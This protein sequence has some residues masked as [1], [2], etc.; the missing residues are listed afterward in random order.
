VPESFRWFVTVFM[1]LGGALLARV[2]AARLFQSARGTLAPAETLLDCTAFFS[3]GLTLIFVQFVDQYF[4]IYLPLA[5]IVVGKS[6]QDLLLRWRA[7][8]SVCCVF[9]LVGATVWTREDLARDEA[10]WT[11]SEQLR[12]E[13]IPAERIFSDWKWLFYWQFEDYVHA[14]HAT[15]ETSYADLFEDGWLK[16]KKEAA[17]F[18]IVRELQPPAGETWKV[19]RQTHYF[20]IYARGRQTFYAIRRIHSSRAAIEAKTMAVAGRSGR[21]YTQSQYAR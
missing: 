20:S 8:V 14:G 2:V 9:L 16:R 19:V 5:T 10:I 13:G 18:W 17:E 12:A 15:P 7:L 3:F 21:Q 1:I 11:L 4:L 6:V